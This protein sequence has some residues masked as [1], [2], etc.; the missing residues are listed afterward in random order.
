MSTWAFRQPGSQ[1]K[2]GDKVEITRSLTITGLG[3]FHSG[4]TGVVKNISP[5]GEPLI[6]IAGRISFY[7]NPSFLRK[8]E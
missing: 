7:A 1:F 3:T 6:E 8:K 5:S 2:I 4:D